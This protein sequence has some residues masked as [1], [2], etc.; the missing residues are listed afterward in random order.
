MRSPAFVIA[1]LDPAIHPLRKTFFSMNARV[2][3]A[4]TRVHSPRRRA[5]TPLRTRFCPR[6]TIWHEGEESAQDGGEHDETRSRSRER[7][8]VQSQGCGFS[9]FSSCSAL[10]ST[11]K[12]SD[13]RETA[14]ADFA[15]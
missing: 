7:N 3:S 12:S 6:M 11:A 10:L 8:R 4:F 2:I 15:F 13:P 14:G 1:G 5:S 9:L